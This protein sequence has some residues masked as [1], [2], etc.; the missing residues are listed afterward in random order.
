M[1]ME[2]EQ[3][4]H[5][6]GKAPVIP[7][8]AAEW[9]LSGADEKSAFDK[10]GPL[11]ELKKTLAEGALNAETGQSTANASLSMSTGCACRRRVTSTSAIFLATLRPRSSTAPP[12]LGRPLQFA[13]TMP[14]RNDATCR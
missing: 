13:G 11:D 1:T 3:A 9:L 5:G 12:A 8:A 6:R 7:D 2:T 14:R 4:S 10:D